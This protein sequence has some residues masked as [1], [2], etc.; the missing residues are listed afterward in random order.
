MNKMELLA[1]EILAEAKAQGADYAQC[2][3]SESEKK[4][5]NVDGGRFSLMRTLYNRNV[6]VTVLKE[7]RKGTVQVNRF[8][9]ETV[10]AAVKDAIAAAESALCSW[11]AVASCRVVWDWVRRLTSVF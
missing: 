3:V 4:E 2:S 8:D 11:A 6:T 10:K 9:S 7:Q 5:F 1:R